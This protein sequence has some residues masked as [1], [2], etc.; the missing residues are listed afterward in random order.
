MLVLEPRFSIYA[1]AA[2]IILPVAAGLAVWQVQLP[3]LLQFLLMLLLVLESAY[4]CS[5]VLPC[6]RSRLLQI[7]IGEQ[8]CQLVLVG[9]NV[10]TELPKLVYGSE[11]LLI[12]EFEPLS[13][14]AGSR[15]SLVLFPDSLPLVQD[16]QLR[17]LLRF[18]WHD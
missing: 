1:A 4:S 3:S 2:S 6:N 11:Y 18:G 13:K 14:H 15:R 8:D 17:R 9:G 5:K 10:N 12:L 16:R 7:R